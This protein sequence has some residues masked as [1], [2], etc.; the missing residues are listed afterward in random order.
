MNF[1]AAALFCTENT[2]PSANIMFVDL[3]FTNKMLF[4][5]VFIII[6]YKPLDI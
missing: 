4:I 5:V 1:Y 2:T 6:L 3:L